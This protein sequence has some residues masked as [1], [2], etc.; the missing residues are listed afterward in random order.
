MRVHPLEP[1]L[2][3]TPCPAGEWRIEPGQT[4]VSRYRFAIG[5]GEPD[6]DDIDRLWSD[7]AAAPRSSGMRP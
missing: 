2:C 6:A 5:D 3:F 4:Y 1:F 7:F